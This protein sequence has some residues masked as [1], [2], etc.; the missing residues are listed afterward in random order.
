MISVYTETTDTTDL[1]Q[2]E[3]WVLYD[4]SC[5][6]CIRLAERFRGRLERAGF[7]LAPLQT[8]WVRQRLGLPE[9][10]LLSEMRV[11]T[12][13]GEVL[14]GA[15]GVVHLVRAIWWLWPLRLASRLPFGM[16][17]LRW[18]YRRVAARRRCDEGACERPTGRMP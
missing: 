10:Q 14:G 16:K 11:L 18:V 9:E 7:R 4:G 2:R 6:L 5:S 12:A 17:L 13:T 1:S 8:P 3:A 15:E